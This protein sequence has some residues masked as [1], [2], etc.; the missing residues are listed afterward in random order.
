VW[1]NNFVNLRYPYEQYQNIENDSDYARLGNDWIERG[2]KL[3]ETTIKYYPQELY[4][5]VH[6]LQIIA[7]EM[8]KNWD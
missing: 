6:A 8:E 1:R 7:A 3:S 4:G 5:I 2:G